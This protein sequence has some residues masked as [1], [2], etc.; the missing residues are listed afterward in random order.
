M[1]DSRAFDCGDLAGVGGTQPEALEWDQALTT[2]LRV[3]QAMWIIN[4]A[5]GLMTLL[6]ESQKKRGPW[7]RHDC[8]CGFRLYRELLVAEW[9][10]FQAFT[11]VAWFSIW[12]GS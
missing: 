9:L 10:G 5:P 6:R 4:K 8:S 7:T 2:Q 11:A 1:S 12:S 3:L